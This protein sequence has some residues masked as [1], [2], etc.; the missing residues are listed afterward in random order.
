[1]PG[2]RSLRR[3]WPVLAALSGAVTLAASTAH[4]QG[5]TAWKIAT[6]KDQLSNRLSRF[7]VTMP[8][9]APVQ[10]GKPVTTALIIK[11]GSALA[12]GATHAELM[13]LFPS[14]PAKHMRTIATRYR[15]DD[16]PVRDYKLKVAGK[17]GAHAILLPKFS[18]QDPVADLVAAKRLRVEVDLPNTQNTL[19]DF[20]VTGAA[21]AVRAIACQ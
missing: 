19:L 4:G 5:A 16:G 10:A 14:L 17:N 7:A 6:E 3:L 15:F 18:D 11:C 13:I 20:N 1:M 12:G 8:K 9:S 2:K 21:D